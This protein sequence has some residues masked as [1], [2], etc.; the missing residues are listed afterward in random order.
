MLEQGAPS[1]ALKVCWEAAR[2][3]GLGA[4]GSLLGCWQAAGLRLVALLALL[5]KEERPGE[6][7]QR[8]AEGCVRQGKAS[9]LDV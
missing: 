7:G 3:R 6:P 8:R 5:G 9:S 2:R 1:L 4:Q